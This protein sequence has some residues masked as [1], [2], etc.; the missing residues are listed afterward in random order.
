MRK[1]Y[2]G[3]FAL[4]KKSWQKTRSAASWKYQLR[5]RSMKGKRETGQIGQ[6]H[7]CSAPF[8]VVRKHGL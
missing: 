7:S 1:S 3:F 6:D 8:A 2:D 4:V 5:K